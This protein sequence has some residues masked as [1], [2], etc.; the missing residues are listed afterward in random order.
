MNYGVS[1]VGIGSKIRPVK[2]PQV[3]HTVTDEKAW[4]LGNPGLGWHP[5]RIKGLS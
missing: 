2:K 3:F 4:I 1:N 5:L